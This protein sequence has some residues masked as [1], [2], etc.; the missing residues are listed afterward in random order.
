MTAFHLSRRSAIAMG[1]AFAALAPRFGYA[2]TGPGPDL[3]DRWLARDDSSTA[4]IDNAAYGAFLKKY[5]VE[6]PD[7]INRVAYGRVEPADKASLDDYVS[8]L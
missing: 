5:V 3:W 2:D 4:T 8:Q 7:G 6:S 1:G